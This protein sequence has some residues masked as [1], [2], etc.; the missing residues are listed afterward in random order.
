[1]RAQ[2]R[3]ENQTASA[4]HRAAVDLFYKQGYAATTLR[5]IADKVGLQVGSLYNHISSKEDVL[6]RIMQEIMNDLIDATREEMDQ[7]SGPLDKVRAFMHASIRFHGKH[8]RETLIGNSELRALSPAKRRS[9]VAL[10]DRYEALLSDA[11]SEAVN[12]NELDIPDEQMAVFAGLAMCAHVASWYRSGHRLDLDQIAD[13]L[14]Q[15]Y[16][17]LGA[18]AHAEV[19]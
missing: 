7:A 15:M 5:Q 18:V 1:M 17:P 3:P 4:I 6:F 14:S 8:R 13:Y 2:G 16:A 9:I 11:I 12:A 19:A 10:R